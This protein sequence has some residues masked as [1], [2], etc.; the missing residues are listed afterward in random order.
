[1]AT[2]L[3]QVD[4]RGE[5]RRRGR[6]L[7]RPLRNICKAARRIYG[8]ELDPKLRGLITQM[9]EQ[10]QQ[11]MRFAVEAYV[12]NDAAW[13]RPSTTWTTSSTGCRSSSSQAIFES[14]AADRIDLQVAV[15]LALVARFYERIGDHAVNIGERVRYVVTGWL[16]EPGAQAKDR[17]DTGGDPAEADVTAAGAALVAG[18]RRRR[19][20]TRDLGDRVAPRRRRW[21][22]A[23]IRASP[24]LPVAGW[25]RPL[26][27]IERVAASLAAP[28]PVPQAARMQQLRRPLDALP[29][30]VVV[31]DR[32]RP[33][34][35]ATRPRRALPRR[36]PRRR[37]RGRGRRTTYAAALA[38]EPSTADPR[39]LRPAPS[40]RR[41]AAPSP[42]SEERR[43]RGHR[44]IEDV[45]E[46]S[47]LDA[48]R[49]DFV[50]NISHELKTPVGA[51]ALLAEALADED[52]AASCSRLAQKMVDEAPRVARIIDDL[53]E[54]SRIELGRPAAAG[55]G[56]RSARWRPRPPTGCATS[57]PS[58]ATS[59]SWST[60][61]LGV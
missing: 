10:A 14:H 31:V 59:T 9:G 56:R 49:T 46:R 19:G 54:L 38:G 5:D 26:E 57:R 51:L 11:L 37:A 27:V 52:D 55:G 18:S 12:E 8:H 47:R 33:C 7:G 42:C 40:H 50:A 2:D 53:L 4:R 34:W 32:R 20:R 45:T 28:M 21:P 36:A 6:A 1:M 43:R 13:P 60:S 3:R 17:V 61:R 25:A 15:Q 22:V 48:M 24:T 44:G 35:C 29:V 30:G 41:G 39:A 16:P 58:S 23:S